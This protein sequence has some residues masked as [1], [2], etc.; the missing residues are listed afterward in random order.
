MRKLAVTAIVIGLCGVT[1]DVIPAQE[2]EDRTLLSW[3]QMRAIINE[4]SGERAMHHVLELVP[5]PR[6]RPPV[7]YEGHFRESEVMA[8]FAREYGYSSVEIESF[9]SP[10]RLWQPTQG[11]LWML[12]PEVRKLYDIYDV[13]VSLA[14]NSETGDA[15]A[16]VVDVGTGA[17]SDDY[18]NKDVKGKI[19]L[20][21]TGAGNLQRLGV[22]ERGAVGV[23]SYTSL[24]P[25]SYPDQIASQSVSTVP[26]GRKTGFGWSIAPRVAREI[27]ALL[28]RGQKVVL[29]SIVKAES[30]PGAMEVVHA[31]IA[32]DGSTNQDV[33]VSGHL[34]EGYLKQGANDDNSGC[35]LT[36]EMGRAY[37]RLAKEGKLP[38]PRRAAEQARRHP[39]ADHCR[40][41]FRHGGGA[42]LHECE[43]LGPPSNTRYFSQFPQ[44]SKRQRPR[45]R[46][47]S[48]PRARALPEH[49]QA[50]FALSFSRMPAPPRA[51]I[52]IRQD[53]VVASCRFDPRPQEV[54]CGQWL[55]PLCCPLS[56]KIF[57]PHTP[58]SPRRVGILVCD[59][60]A[61]YRPR[62]PEATVFYQVFEPQFDN[63]V[64]A[65]EERFE[66]RSGPLRRVVRDSVGQFLACGR[67]QGGFARVRCPS[68][69]S[70]HL[71]AFS[72]APR[73]R[74]IASA[75]MTNCS[76][77]RHLPIP[78][79]ARPCAFS[80][81]ST[82]STPS[83]P[84]SRIAG[85]IARGIME[86]SPT[87]HDR[88]KPS[89]S[90]RP[91]RRQA[92]T[93]RPIPPLS[94]FNDAGH[95]GPAPSRRF[96]RWILFYVCAAQR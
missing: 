26:E 37:I 42:A 40:S 84:T 24:R 75:A 11:E 45:V 61:V 85:G 33:I 41:E 27:S 13:A 39:Q 96:S 7:E 2:R 72:P 5:Y 22:F 17:R 52:R 38:T 70:E 81:P 32:G 73:L 56:P 6:V 30:F 69:K 92:L 35:A 67:L 34:Y 79:P 65:Y 49:Y 19:V 57:K 14:A 12:E 83:R 48:Q 50:S 25:D 1:F 82:G 20:G 51:I 66:P 62:H 89:A 23:A 47:E 10:G 18:A 8:K 90:S 54:D 15:S 74:P 55:T 58:V 44:L 93:H 68:C 78:A 94:S 53:F 60:P 43:L 71:L 76:R 95:R 63:Y 86:R 91:R 87:A 46:R 64:A 77:S 80:I 21:S 31:T 59:P 9:P 4:A 29:R 3:D 88:R 36:L 28:S 16:E